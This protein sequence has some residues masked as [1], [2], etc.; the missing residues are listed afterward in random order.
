MMRDNLSRDPSQPLRCVDQPYASLNALIRARHA[1]THAHPCFL[2]VVGM[3]CKERS[4]L[5]AE[6]HHI[7]SVQQTHSQGFNVA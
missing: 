7:H 6:S 2:L 4:K 1:V 3:H 5:L